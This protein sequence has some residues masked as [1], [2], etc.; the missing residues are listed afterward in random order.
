[1]TTHTCLARS[2]PAPTA[3]GDAPDCPD[4]RAALLQAFRE[5]A[6]TPETFRPAA[7]ALPDEHHKQN[8]GENACLEPELCTAGDP[9]PVCEEA[10]PEPGLSLAEHVVSVSVLPPVA[11]GRLGSWS[12]VCGACGW[13]R[14]GRYGSSTVSAPDFQQAENLAQAWARYHKTLTRE[15]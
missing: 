5:P 6:Q 14:T 2:G 4:C 8:P 1:M 7:P 15:N 12:V 9:C 3:P 13:R 10:P 11:P